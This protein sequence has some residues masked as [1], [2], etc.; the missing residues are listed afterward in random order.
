MTFYILLRGNPHGSYNIEVYDS[1]H[2]WGRLVYTCKVGES[3][4]LGV[5][6]KW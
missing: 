3:Y 5:H 6:R 2:L 4:I 1:L